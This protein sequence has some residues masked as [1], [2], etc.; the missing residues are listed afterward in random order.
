[1]HI[2]RIRHGHVELALTKQLPSRPHLTSFEGPSTVRT[3]PR[4]C[5]CIPTTCPN[6]IIATSSS[7]LAWL[8]CPLHGWQRCEI[9]KDHDIRSI[10]DEPLYSRSLALRCSF[11]Y[12]LAVVHRSPLTQGSNVNLL[13]GDLVMKWINSSLLYRQ[14]PARDKMCKFP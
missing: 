2:S 9:C 4:N 13:F 3:I 7:I 8:P 5:S 1:L 10:F 6:P 11:A 14:G 12:K